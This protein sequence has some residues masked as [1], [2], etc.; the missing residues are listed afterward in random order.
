MQRLNRM[1][2]V[3]ALGAMVLLPVSASGGT[4]ADLADE[5]GLDDTTRAAVREIIVSTHDALAP[6]RHSLQENRR[7]L[8]AMLAEEQPDEAAV[9]KQLD[10]VIE[11]ERDLWRQ[12]LQALIR[13]RS[14]LTPEQR[15][16]VAGM[17]E[18]RIGGA[19]QRFLRTA[20]ACRGDIERY[21]PGAAGVRDSVRCLVD[22]RERVSAACRDALAAGLLGP[23]F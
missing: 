1:A 15:E 16:Q 19:K 8:R 6:V 3:A 10:A 4:L 18:N 2:M 21:C 11:L 5:L 7:R 12:R 23:L 13:V 22:N 14:L 17:L 9:M 20:A